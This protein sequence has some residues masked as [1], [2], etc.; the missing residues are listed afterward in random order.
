MNK[1]NS[2]NSVLYGISGRLR[3][4]LAFLS[5]D[6]KANAEEIRLRS[7]QP[8][9]ITSRGKPLFVLKNGGISD[10]VCADMLIA[11]KEDLQESFL[12]LCRNSVFAHEAELKNGYIMMKNGHRAGIGGTLNENG[13]VSNISSI[14]IRIS[15]DIKGCAKHLAREYD[16][17]GFLIAGPPG[18][19]KTTML[20]DL[21]RQLSSGFPFGVYRRISVIDSRGEISGSSSGEFSNNLGENTDILM[22][23]NKALGTE[24]ALRTLFPDIIAFDE[25]GTAAELKGVAGCFHSGVS[26]I[27]TV[28]AGSKEDLIRRSV[29]RELIEM[30]A[31]SKIALLN[32]NFNVEPT[33]INT[34][35]LLCALSLKS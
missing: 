14:N 22:I 5:E 26:V 23:K 2:F 16:G 18:S 31:I 13:V 4:T 17:G 21:I 30:N 34:K 15:H 7:G 28:H 11:L 8:V 19:G 12:L 25:I 24:I 35:D 20:R 6:I 1:E 3:R 32:G 33:I 9:C 29:I 10:F 27:T